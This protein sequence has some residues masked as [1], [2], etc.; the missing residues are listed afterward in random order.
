MTG[1]EFYVLSLVQARAAGGIAKPTYSFSHIMNSCPSR[2]QLTELLSDRLGQE[3]REALERHVGECERCQQVLSDLADSGESG[4]WERLLSR[5]EEKTILTARPAGAGELEPSA[6]FLDRLRSLRGFAEPSAPEPVTL[7]VPAGSA[8]PA[9]EPSVGARSWPKLP[10]YEILRELGRGGM[11]V[12]YLAR[13]ALLNRLVALKMIVAGVD[14]NPEYR[15]RLLQEAR[16]VAQLHHP[17]IVAIYD[18]GEHEDRLFLS[19]EYVSGGSLHDRVHRTPQ[20]PAA[21]AR[22]VETLA[23]AMHYAHQY[24]IVHR[25]LKPA[26]VLLQCEFDAGKQENDETGRQGDRETGRQE[27]FVPK[28]TDFGVAK[29]M[30]DAAGPTRTGAF[31]GTPSYMAPEQAGGVGEI[32]PRTDVYALG[33]IL[34]EL[35]TGRPPFWSADPLDTLLQ[36][37]FQ[38]P[39]PPTTLQPTVPRDLM[40]ICLK[41]LQKDSNQRYASALDLAEDLRRFRAGE[42]IEARP[43]GPIEKAR[44]FVR[45]HPVAAGSLAAALLA[46]GAG[47]A[48]LTYGYIAAKN[49]F[50]AEAARRH[51]TE[52]DLYF[53]YVSLSDHLVRGQDFQSASV[54]LEKC[55][56]AEGEEDHRRWEWYYLR[57]VCS[58]PGVQ[59]SPRGD[60]RNHSVARGGAGRLITPPPGERPVDQLAF[61]ADGRELM[62]LANKDRLVIWLDPQNGK[63]VRR[64][65]LPLPSA[66]E[67]TAPVKSLALS[68]DGRLLAAA[69]VDSA[70][71]ARAQIKIWDAAAGRELLSWR[72]AAAGEV[73]ALAF[74]PQTPRLA[75]CG[76]DGTISI[77]DSTSGKEVVALA[78][79]VGQTGCLAFSKD[80][81]WFASSGPD[82]R[83]VSI[84]N[85][86]NGKIQL[87]LS[88]HNHPVTGVAFCPDNERLV[89]VDCVGEVRLWDTTGGHHALTLPAL[90]KGPSMKKRHDARVATSPDGRQIAATNWDGTI[91]IW[92]ADEQK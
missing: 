17:N 4:L 1:A 77:W 58:T 52:K 8:Q 66:S 7:T 23:L 2:E 3:D 87:T 22:L 21:A 33:A 64:A 48:G 78:G 24:G 55:F 50:T 44:H 26:N 86:G 47:F 60:A 70:P 10:A 35:L 71:A 5:R 11:S 20:V 65:S 62:L 45:R 67:Q 69:A 12:V 51:A 74:S 57:H 32:G 29:L 40:T 68:P 6:E 83:S 80:G 34:Y 89:S 31:V 42:P 41:C 59:R 73:V 37:R 72:A 25:D 15:F 79:H 30:N 19:L 9:D 49:A 92:D 75:T 91:S 56:P 81:S 84:W 90:A 28:I 38:E 46:I 61:S 85:A 82:D 43:P 13:Q 63:L 88:G 54:L 76:R 18:I 53:A 36:V 14:A 39:V 27:S 16:A